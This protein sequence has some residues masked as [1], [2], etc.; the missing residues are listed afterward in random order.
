MEEQVFLKGVAKL[1]PRRHP[2][3]PIIKH[4]Y[5]IL[6]NSGNKNKKNKTHKEDRK[7]GRLG[8][9]T[10]TRTKVNDKFDKQSRPIDLRSVKTS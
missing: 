4:F 5:F 1:T 3:N 6:S 2:I 9:R 8:A 10:R 7:M